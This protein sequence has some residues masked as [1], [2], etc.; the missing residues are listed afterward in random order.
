MGKDTVATIDLGG[1]ST[2]VTFDVKNPNSVPSLANS[3]HTISTSEAEMNVF[4]NSY[5]NLGLKAAR[6]VFFTSGKTTDTINYVSECINPIVKS[7]EFTY[8]SKTYFMSGKNNSASTEMKPVVDLDACIDSI[9]Q[10][11]MP[12]VNP[13]PIT[14]NEHE[15]T[16]FSYIIHR[17]KIS[18][19]IREYFL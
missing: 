10:R 3:I 6:H 18:G 2:Q 5:L 8:A 19:I 16:A 9:K 15:I 11:V 4:S 1:G 13:K 14:L 12:L 17:A 7:T